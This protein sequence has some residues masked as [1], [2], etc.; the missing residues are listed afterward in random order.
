MLG[1]EHFSYADIPTKDYTTSS[2]TSFMN[3]VHNS[4]QTGEEEFSNA[5]QGKP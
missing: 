4:T 2:E 1:E 5:F 3:V